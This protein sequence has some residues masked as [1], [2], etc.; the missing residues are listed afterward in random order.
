[1]GFECDPSVKKNGK[2]CLYIDFCNL[3]V[4]TPK[5]EYLM[6]IADL[7]IDGGVGHRIWTFMDKHSSYDQIFI[8]ESDIHKTAFQCQESIRTFE[9]LMMSLV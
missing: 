1:M 8:S 2:L 9:W 6:S 7:L 3:N 4:A 5:D